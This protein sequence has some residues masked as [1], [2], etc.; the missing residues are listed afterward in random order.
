MRHDIKFMYQRLQKLGYRF[1]MEDKLT[2]NK[3]Q[4]FKGTRFLENYE[5]YMADAIVYCYH[6][7]VRRIP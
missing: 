7:Y 3:L 5:G 1:D 2:M 4:F 6:K